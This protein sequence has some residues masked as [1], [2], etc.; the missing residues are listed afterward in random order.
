M[1][2]VDSSAIVAIIRKEDDG[3]VFADV[4]D[5]QDRIWMSAVSY[6]ETNMV[7]NGRRLDVE[8]LNVDEILL[9][10][11]IEVVPLSLESGRAA[12]SGFMKFGKG[13]HRARLNFADCFSYGLAKNHNLPLLFKGDDFIHTDIVPAWRP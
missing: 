5:G 9:A 7:V 11:G 2:V 3:P 8:L 6:V 10:M 13:R 4:I 12:V 1:I